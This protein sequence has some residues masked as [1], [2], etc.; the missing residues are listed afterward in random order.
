ML[1]IDTKLMGN[2]CFYIHSENCNRYVI[3]SL[4]NR[5]EANQNKIGKWESMIV[6]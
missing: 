6:V 4:S 1:T 3:D 5:I 2:A